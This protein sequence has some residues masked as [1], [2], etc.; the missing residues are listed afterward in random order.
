MQTTDF[1]ANHQPTEHNVRALWYLH[2]FH[3]KQPFSNGLAYEDLL[4]QCRL[5]YTLASLHRIDKLLDDIR[6]KTP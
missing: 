1:L 6:E 2:Q 3:A 4:H 5:D